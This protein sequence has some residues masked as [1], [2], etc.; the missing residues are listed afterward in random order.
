MAGRRG[1]PRREELIMTENKAQKNAVR[2]RMAETGESYSVAR[3]AI[4][5]GASS[6]RPA[7]AWDEKMRKPGRA[8]DERLRP[9]GAWSERLRGGASF[10]RLPGLEWLADL[11][12]GEPPRPGRWFPGRSET[13][14]APVPPRPPRPPR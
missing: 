13:R 1:P 5:G 14:Q 11:A 2:R 8:W 12:G 6:T 10:A 3:R 4:L 9:P 7:H